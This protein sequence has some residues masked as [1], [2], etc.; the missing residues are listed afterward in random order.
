MFIPDP[1]FYQ[2][3]VSVPGSKNGNKREVKK[4]SDLAL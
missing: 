4:M 1:D 3:F 2:S